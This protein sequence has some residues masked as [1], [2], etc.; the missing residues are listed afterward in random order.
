MLAALFRCYKERCYSKIYVCFFSPNL[1]PVLFI[2][3]ISVADLRTLLL[4]C[5]FICYSKDSHERKAVKGFRGINPHSLYPQGHLFHDPLTAS[6]SL[7]RGGLTNELP[8]PIMGLQGFASRCPSR[9]RTS[10]GGGEDKS[11]SF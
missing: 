9:G 10:F 8:E 6:L 4:V 5:L 1:A 11:G 7:A 3:S 2:F